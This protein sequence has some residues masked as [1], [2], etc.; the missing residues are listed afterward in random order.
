M[1]NCVKLYMQT[2]PII[3]YVKQNKTKKLF[4]TQALGKGFNFFIS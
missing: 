3:I 4:L 1:P 2:T